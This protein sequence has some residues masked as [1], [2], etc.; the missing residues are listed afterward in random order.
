MGFEVGGLGVGWDLDVGGLWA[1][2]SGGLGG[3]DQG[4][5]SW[6]QKKERLL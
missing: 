1:R 2:F 5:G 4:V 3:L 6:E